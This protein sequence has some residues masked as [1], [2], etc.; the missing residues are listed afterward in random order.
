MNFR[1]SD[2]SFIPDSGTRAP[3]GGPGSWRRGAPFLLLLFA[4]VTV[5]GA[6]SSPEGQR[7]ADAATGRTTSTAAADTLD[8]HRIP[9]RG[10]AWVIFGNDTVRAEVAETPE[11]REEGLMYRT[12]VPEGTGMLFVFE[13]EA[14]RSFWMRNTYV[15]LDIAFMSAGMEIVDIQQMEPETEEYHSSES[16]AM[17]ALEVPQGWF[18]EHGIE[19][20]DQAEIA[21]GPR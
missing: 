21:F 18:Q 5:P 1:D 13:N 2:P 8:R 16:P 4:I 3:A 15:P 17:Y 11:A 6:C 10:E 20:G 7:D 19:E 9:P 14:N 12:E